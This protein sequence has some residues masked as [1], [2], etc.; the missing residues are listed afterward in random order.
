MSMPAPMLSANIHYGLG[1][2][3]N[4]KRPGEVRID[5][6]PEHAPRNMVSNYADM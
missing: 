6:A 2:T 3:D 5:L 1:R 4:G